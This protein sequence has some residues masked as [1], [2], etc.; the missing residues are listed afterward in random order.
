M[1]DP[2]YEVQ[3]VDRLIAVLNSGDEGAEATRQYREIMD[4]LANNIQEHGGSHKAELAIKIKFAADPKGLDV[5]IET[6]AKMPKR[7]VI[8]ERFF[9][10][11]KNT[12][13]LQ[14]PAKDSLF[15]GADLGRRRA[16]PS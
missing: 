14:D 12:L 8:K 7:P 1:A 6:T 3:T 4:R 11:E 5:T 13:T 16:M 2:A 9:M 15:E 10:S